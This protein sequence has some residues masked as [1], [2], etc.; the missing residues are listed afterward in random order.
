MP[1]KR[2]KDTFENN[3]AK[4]E[5]CMDSSISNI[6][7]DAEEPINILVIGKKKFQEVE[8]SNL[9]FSDFS[10]RLSLVMSSTPLI[11]SKQNVL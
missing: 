9:A 4:L 1:I 11:I 7:V 3:H 5:L 8:Q 6:D 2:T 10:L